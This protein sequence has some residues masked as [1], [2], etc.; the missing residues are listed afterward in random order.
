VID[1]T[2]RSVSKATTWK[3]LGFI[4][5]SLVTYAATGSIKQT[6]LVAVLY[7]FI[8]LLIYIFH[9]KLW[10]KVQWGKTSGL[11]IQMTGMSGAGKTTLATAVGV[12]L[13]QKGIKLEI[14]DGD[15]YREN[16]CK[17]L[18]FRREDREENIK[19]LS[20][21]G[22]VLGRNNVVCIMSAIN[23]YSTT[24]NHIR[25]HILNSK[26]VYIKCNLEELKKRDTK[27]L[28]KRALLPDGDPDKVLNFTGISDPFDTPL[29]PDLVIETDA[30]SIEN[31]VAKIEKFILKEIGH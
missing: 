29:K 28:Y 2:K 10:N 14:I 9:E 7:H 8:M 30:L 19:R 6:S 21:V 17:D 11:F 20:F 24:R 1:S 18:G 4:I 5:L 26:L 27:G 22:K 25:K 31:S 3:V 16:L 23:P 12:S 15:E 13:K